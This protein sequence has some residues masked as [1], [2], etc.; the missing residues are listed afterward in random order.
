MATFAEPTIPRSTPP[1]GVALARIRRRWRWRHAAVG[2]AIT[3]AVLLVGF[4]V[5]AAA[6]QGARFSPASVAIAR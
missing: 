2:V 6:L 1:F 5:A 3:L 4:W